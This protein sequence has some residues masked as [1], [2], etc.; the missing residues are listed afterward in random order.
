M[1]DKLKDISDG[2]YAQKSAIRVTRAS[3]FFSRRIRPRDWPKRTGQSS[4]KP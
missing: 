3:G 4:G 1:Y 2:H